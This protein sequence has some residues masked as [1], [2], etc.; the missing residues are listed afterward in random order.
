MCEKSYS[1]RP[2]LWV[3]HAYPQ[4]D[5][6]ACSDGHLRLL[7]ALDISEANND[8]ACVESAWDHPIS[9]FGQHVVQQTPDTL[10]VPLRQG[11]VGLFS[12]LAPQGLS[13]LN[14]AGYQR[15]QQFSRPQ[16]PS[17]PFDKDLIGQY[18]L[19]PLHGQVEWRQERP[20][21]LSAWLH[22]TNACNLDCAYCYV[23]K[24]SAYMSDEVGLQAIESLF[25]A[26]QR[27]GFREIKL[28]YAGGEPTLRFSL[29]RRLHHRAYQLSDKTGIRV[30][31]VLLT[32]G[33]HIRIRDARWLKDAGIKVAISLDG[34]G[35]AHDQQRPMA[36]GRGSF[37]LIEHTIDEVLLP[38]GI[39]PDI[40]LTITRW[41]AS[42]IADAVH[43]VLQRN[44]PL[45]LNFHRTNPNIQDPESL[46]LEE[47]AIIEGMKAA[48]AVFE[49]Y[50][51][52]RPFLDGLLD[53]VQTMAHTQT[54]GVDNNY[55]VITHEGKLTQCQMTL[56]KARSHV[57]D[58]IALPELK[59]SFIHNVPVDDKE[60]C[61]TCPF[62]YRCSG[63][64]PLETYRLTGRWD[65]KSPHCN[66]YKALYPL[67]LR[68]E[69]L[70]I[71]K[72]N[73]LLQ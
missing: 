7:A 29:V 41:N 59:G 62:R 47:K 72:V 17:Q 42:G 51:P 36:N 2:Q 19:L 6:C 27:Y 39:Y 48:Y 43:W 37:A 12:P 4:D 61:K 33:V 70:R 1:Q 28:K 20:L 56:G 21:T 44:L 54:C 14:M 13:V 50:L 32:N 71:M 30:K 69:G 18:L 8:C 64:C 11:Y 15:W 49:S 23:R 58:G 9:S 53:R 68:L 38:L 57:A 26:A 60:G 24:S 45:S 5:D 25:D 10:V 63:G 35:H 34:I 55:V 3:T 22:I 16:T 52:E 46:E 67:A 66:I 65:V 40:T 73:G 31:E